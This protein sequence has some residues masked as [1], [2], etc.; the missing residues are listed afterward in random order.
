MDTLTIF[1]VIILSIG[2]TQGLVFGTILWHKSEK[3]FIANRYKA[4]FLFVLSYGLLNQVLRQ[5][6]IGIYDTWY[7]LTLDLSWSYGL[8]I[9]L[10][11]KAQVIPDFKLKR[12]D[13][14]LFT[15]VIV[16][17]ACSIFVRSQNFYW[18][19]T[20][21]SLSWLGYYGYVYW[22]NYPSVPIIASILIIVFSLKSLKL[23]NKVDSHEVVAQNLRWVKNLVKAYG[24]YYVIVLAIL[25]I[26]LV[27]YTTS[28][29]ID[30]FYFTRFYYYPFFIGT[31]ILIY[32]FGISSII[33][34]DQR[35]LHVKRKLP[36]SERI[37][38]E[39]L[40]K[41]LQ[42]IMEEDKAFKDSTLTLTS[43]A[44]QLTIKPYLLTKVL[45][46][47]L[48]KSF[49]DYV[50]EY[51]V[52]EVDRLVNDPVNDKFTLLSIAFDSGFNSKSSFNRAVKK[53]LGL[54]PN[55]LKRKS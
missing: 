13:L 47:V 33:R 49:T 42:L 55:E 50:N 1:L 38:L 53:H 37:Q 27:I 32:W 14:W 21:E 6:G 34:A 44:D 40:A 28:I 12:N 17:L 4:I 20:R 45:N 39:E 35:V 29:S 9:F 10:Y 52:S 48:H 26:D 46:D 7:H 15:P 23:L 36:E 5:F 3:G 11:V 30:Y 16:Q 19:G 51:R 2:L 54:A 41:K 18:D 8:L 24:A 31:A 22:M 25:V 43:L